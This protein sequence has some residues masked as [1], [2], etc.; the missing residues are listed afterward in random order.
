M[1]LHLLP[2]FTRFRRRR[3]FA[4][5][6]NL[7]V[8]A[9]L[10]GIASIASAA[11]PPAATT[12]PVSNAISDVTLARSALAAIDAEPQLKGANLVV[13]VVDRVAVIGGPVSSAKQSQCAEQIVRAVS[14]ISDVRNTCFVAIGPDPLLRS[15]A[16]RMESPLPPRPMFLELPGVLTNQ[17]TPAGPVNLGTPDPGL[18]AANTAPSAVIVRKPAGDTGVLGAPVSSVASAA[19]PGTKS[20]SFAPPIVAPTAPGVLTGTLPPALAKPGDVLTA[21]GDVRKT[22]ARFAK[23]TVDLRDGALVIGGSAPLVSDAWDFAKKLQAI[24]GV[25]R[26]RVGAIAGK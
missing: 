26:V 20:V 2:D 12:A 5:L 25:T 23:L 7:A 21:A 8:A 4:I 11:E 18:V 17:L 13:S 6:R 24:P 1:S 14:G 3:P 15:V 19:S 10:G 16:N 9:G 22:D